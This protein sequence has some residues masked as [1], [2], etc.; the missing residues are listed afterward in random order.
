GDRTIL[1]MHILVATPDRVEHLVET[2]ELTLFADEGYRAAFAG[3]GLTV[4]V[5]PSPH[6]DRDR[7]VG[8][9]RRCQG[10]PAPPGLEP[11]HRSP[12]GTGHAPQR[13]EADR[14]GRRAVAV[15]RDEGVTCGYPLARVRGACP[16]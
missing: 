4:E 6:P 2:H 5:H 16:L 7:D 1:V 13:R 12:I 15:G 14:G 3:A 9:R 10:P 11:P 8:L